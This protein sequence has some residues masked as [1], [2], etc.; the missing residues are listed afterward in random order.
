MIRGIGTDI[1][2]ISRI[3]SQM[4]KYGDKFL[5]KILTDPEIEYCA[6]YK[7]SA[8]HV[9][10]RFAAKEAIAKALG[11]GFG[12]EIN[13]HDI[14]IVNDPAGKPIPH[15]S[16]KLNDLFD[17]PVIHLSISHCKSLAVGYAIWEA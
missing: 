1:I 10:G 8:P 13:F 3:A 11:K 7:F 14:E 9:A 17:F 15:L 4:E 2:E 5:H 16:S 12:E 6:R